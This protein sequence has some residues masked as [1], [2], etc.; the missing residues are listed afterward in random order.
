MLTAGSSAVT[1]LSLHANQIIS[2]TLEFPVFS[3]L[4]FCLTYGIG[5]YRHAL[6]SIVNR[7]SR[8]SLRTQPLEIAL[9]EFP[10]K[11]NNENK[12]PSL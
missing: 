3:S 5:S 1:A 10:V 7:P 6:L 11:K 2:K 8:Y 12:I 9:R 4:F